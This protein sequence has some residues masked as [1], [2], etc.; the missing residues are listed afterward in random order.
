MMRNAYRRISQE[1]AQQSELQLNQITMAYRELKAVHEG[2]PER[3]EAARRAERETS[4]S[5]AG[6]D[7]TIQ[8]L[9]VQLA[10][11]QDELNALQGSAEAR[12]AQLQK[13]LDSE[14]QQHEQTMS[15]AQQRWE[16]RLTRVQGDKVM[17]EAYAD[18]IKGELKAV[19]GRFEMMHGDVRHRDDC[20]SERIKKLET[21]ALQLPLPHNCRA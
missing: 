13:T 21:G 7:T 19:Q 5:V 14:R 8:A 10:A 9:Q 1:A 2:L 17:A 11:K 12:A 16:E 20:S 6:R 18:Q 3:Y 15:S 4:D